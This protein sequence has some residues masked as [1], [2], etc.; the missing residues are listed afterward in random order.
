MKLRAAIPSV[1]QP[2]HIAFVRSTYG[3]LYFNQLHKESNFACYLLRKIRQNKMILRVKFVN[4][5]RE[6]GKHLTGR[7][8]AREPILYFSI[9]LEQTIATGTR[10]GC[11]HLNLL[12]RN[13]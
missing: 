9:I 6:I 8:C 4:E 1:R 13:I 5:L 7:N 12:R 2:K 11:G 3:N 10:S